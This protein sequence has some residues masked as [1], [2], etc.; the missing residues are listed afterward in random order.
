MEWIKIGIC[1]F[2]DNSK[3]TPAQGPTYVKDIPEEEPNGN[4]LIGLLAVLA[5]CFSSGFSGVYFEK[6][7]K[8]TSQS[9]WIRNTQ[10]A[11]FG[12]IVGLIAMF[13]QD[14]DLVYDNGFFQGYTFLTWIVILLQAF[15][16]LIVALVMKYADNILKGFATSISIV[17]STICSYYLL[18]DFEPNYSFII[19]ASVVISANL[20]YACWQYVCLNNCLVNF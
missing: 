15:G 2:F 11:L 10:L 19:G 18:T 1:G 5:S 16:G 13:L 4:R 8:F 9:L 7:V 20:L 6:L 3:Y 17:L 12:V 14:F